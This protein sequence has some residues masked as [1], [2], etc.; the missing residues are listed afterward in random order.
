MKLDPGVSSQ[1]LS[2]LIGRNQEPV[3]P[4][5][6]EAH[7]ALGLSGHTM[8]LPVYFQLSELDPLVVLLPISRVLCFLGYGSLPVSFTA[9][10]PV[11]SPE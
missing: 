7:S 5:F 9:I 3:P 10:S 11:P 8:I 6:L 1:S 2:F 4:S